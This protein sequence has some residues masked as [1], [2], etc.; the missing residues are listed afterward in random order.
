MRMV[1]IPWNIQ[2]L[3]FSV[4]VVANNP[5]DKLVNHSMAVWRRMVCTHMATT[6]ANNLLVWG[7]KC[8]A[9]YRCY[10]KHYYKYISFTGATPGKYPL[11]N[12]PNIQHTVTLHKEVAFSTNVHLCQQKYINKVKV[13]DKGEIQISAHY[14]IP[15]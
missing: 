2:K 7:L 3:G 6:F 12:S 13:T 11:I 4:S 10:V 1:K 5:T 8:F 15:M 9:V 14:S